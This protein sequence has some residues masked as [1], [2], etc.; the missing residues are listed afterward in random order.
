MPAVARSSPEE[1][2]RRRLSLPAYQVQ[3]AARY[4]HVT[5]QTVRNWQKGATSPALAPRE[6]RKALTYMQLIE[7]AVVAALQQEGVRLRQI[8][9]TREWL[10]QRFSSEFPFAEYRFKTDGKGL[11]MDYAQIAGQR[12]GKGKLIRPDMQGQLAWTAVIGRLKEFDYEKQHRVIRWRVGGPKSRIIIDPRVSF[13]APM[14]KGAATWAI[15]GRWEAGETP[16]EIA[17]DFSLRKE[18][19][20]DALTFEGIDDAQLR[21]WLN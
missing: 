11:F 21:K 6:L 2:W 3:E 18:D 7:V 10:Q 12:Q 9:D 17:D 14:I 1:A 8:R 16:E 5:P 13:G 20:I 19:V 15:K 4:A